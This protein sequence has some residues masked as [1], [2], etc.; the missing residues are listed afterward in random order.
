MCEKEK[1]WMC[2]SQSL[3]VLHAIYACQLK[4]LWCH[5]LSSS[6]CGQQRYHALALVDETISTD[7]EIFHSCSLTQSKLRSAGIL[8]HVRHFNAQCRVVV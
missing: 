4:I 8:Q 6:L 5:L 2:G 7:F 1:I 3:S